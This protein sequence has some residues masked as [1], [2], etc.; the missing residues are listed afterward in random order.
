MG[1]IVRSNPFE[2]GRLVIADMA[3]D[4]GGFRRQAIDYMS[5]KAVV[6][7]P[8]I[9]QEIPIHIGKAL[10]I[11]QGVL[12]IAGKGER[13]LERGADKTLMVVGSR[14]QQV[15]ENFFFGPFVF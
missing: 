9:N 8:E 15:A 4:G 2:R 7:G 6:S 14:V 13:A 5:E 11:D 3:G 1:N 12:V 10:E